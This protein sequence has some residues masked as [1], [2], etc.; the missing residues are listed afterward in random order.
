[1]V[2]SET[3]STLFASLHPIL[4][5]LE[6]AMTAHRTALDRA[7]KASESAGWHLLKVDPTAWTAKIEAARGNPGE[8]QQICVDYDE[9]ALYCMSTWLHWY[10]NSRKAMDSRTNIGNVVVDTLIFHDAQRV[11]GTGGSY[12]GFYDTQGAKGTVCVNSYLCDLI[13]ARLLLAS[14]LHLQEYVE[15]GRLA[16]AEHAMKHM[17]PVQVAAFKSFVTALPTNQRG[18]W[19]TEDLVVAPAKPSMNTGKPEGIDCRRVWAVEFVDC[20]NSKHPA[21]ARLADL[22]AQTPGIFDGL[23]QAEA[24]LKQEQN[25]RVNE[26]QHA[27]RLLE[28]LHAEGRHGVGSGGA[29]VDRLVREQSKRRIDYETF[30][31]L[32]GFQ[33]ELCEGQVRAIVAALV[34][35]AGEATQLLTELEAKQEP[36]YDR[37][38]TSQIMMNN[39]LAADVSLRQWIRRLRHQKKEGMVDLSNGAGAR[40]L[41]TA[42]DEL[43]AFYNFALQNRR[44]DIAIAASAVGGE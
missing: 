20:V 24:I 29:T 21:S 14:S 11:R 39:C 7:K 9:E 35:A 17:Q 18:N 15:D 40:S 38:L 28:F 27:H 42:I 12:G 32:F 25:G 31:R 23:K 4:E 13:G 36:T 6:T 26:R 44:E 1:M 8:L 22:L 5:S 3:S 33:V 19:Y 2:T 37:F 41:K 10:I 34:A 43:R 30:H 16:L